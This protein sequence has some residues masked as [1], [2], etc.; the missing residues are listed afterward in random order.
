MSEAEQADYARYQDDLRYQAS[1][2]ESNYGLG[3]REGREAGITE[4]RVE[5]Q[6]R[7]LR[8]LLERRFGVLPEWATRRL[9]QATEQELEAWAE[10]ILTAQ[11]LEAVFA[12]CK[13]Q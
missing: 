5:G 9:S 7:L 10:A 12:P 1:L 6:T 2:V 8:K 4:G 13:S 11:T 3:L